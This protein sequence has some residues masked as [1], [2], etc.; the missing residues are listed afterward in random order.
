MDVGTNR[1]GVAMSPKQSKDMFEAAQAARV[2]PGDEGAMA[3]VRSAYSG[4]RE[5]IGTMPP[6][7]S[8][9]GVVKTAGKV[10][11]GQK[12]TVFLDKLGERLAFERTGTRLYEAVRAKLAGFGGGN[13]VGIHDQMLR[14]IQTQET[15][16]MQL[17]AEAIEKLG[18]DP[19]TETPSAD[20]AGVLSLGI[21]QVLTDPRTTIPQCLNALLAAELVDN[22]SWEMLVQMAQD[23]GYDEMADD[24]RRALQEE[25]M[26]LQHV[27]G[28]LAEATRLEMH[29]TDASGG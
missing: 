28:W 4:E 20:V 1:T 7:A 16:H 17:L 9:K 11:K 27:K 15:E 2:P 8:V 6:P 19:T 18:A 21:V 13:G 3:A 29:G 12:P 23:G 22:A 24:F 5:L 14:E 26:H 25:Q 10:M